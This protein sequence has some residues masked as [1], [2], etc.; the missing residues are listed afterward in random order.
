MM[1][2]NG[3]H[4]E[5]IFDSKYYISEPDPMNPPKWWFTYGNNVIGI[6][7][8]RGFLQNNPNMNIISK[9]YTWF[10]QGLLDT[11]YPN[12]TL[13][14]LNAVQ[15]YNYGINQA[16]ADRLEKQRKKSEKGS[17]KR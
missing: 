1:C 17:K 15:S 8:C 6:N 10:D 5:D 3:S 16:Q 13:E 14:F 12:P 11:R 4:S 9:A 7:I 2:N